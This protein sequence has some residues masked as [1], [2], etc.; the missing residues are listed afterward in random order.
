MYV[1]WV[2]LAPKRA[3]CCVVVTWDKRIVEYLEECIGDYS[4]A[5]S[6][7]NVEDGF[8]WT[9]AGKYGP[10]LDSS[11]RLL[12]DEI[13]GFCSWCEVPWCIGGDFNVKLF[14]LRGR[15]N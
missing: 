5:S 15:L 7:K 13:V 6:F 2:F 4:V 12:W 10:N 8:V 1:G 3:L 9:F 14:H 11:R